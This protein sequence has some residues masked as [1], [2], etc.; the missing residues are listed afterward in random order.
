MSNIACKGLLGVLASVFLTSC[1]PTLPPDSDVPMRPIEHAMGTTQVPISPQRV[2]VLDYAP[3]DTALALEV[4]PIGR[5]EEA[6]S[7]IYPSASRDIT[8]IGA[9]F[10]PNLETILELEPDLILGSKVIERGAYRRLSRIAPT[11]FTEDNGRHGNWQEHFLLHADTLGQLAK[12]EELL[13]DYQERVNTLKFDLEQ[14]MPQ[15][16]TVSVVAHWSG[17]VLAYT[18]NSFSGSVLQDLGFNRN[19]IQAQSSRYALQPSKEELRAIDGDIVFLMYNS[20]SEG[21]ITKAEFVSDPL[22]STLN[23][24]EQGLV[25]EVNSAIWAGGRSIL[26]ANQIL[27]DIEA[28]LTR[29]SP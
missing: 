26:A 7:P 21:S 8:S 1:Q 3:L 18:A 24:V 10:Y 23:A 28:C 9:G 29:T 13:A 4:P 6:I 25:C 22:W 12:A 20:Q 2:I 14:V 16:P 11:I 15:N 19:P 5:P 27:T 17:G